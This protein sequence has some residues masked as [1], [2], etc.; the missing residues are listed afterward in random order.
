MEQFGIK[1][2]R[3]WFKRVIKKI[4][5]KAGVTRAAIGI[6]TGARAEIYF[7]GA[8]ESVSFDAIEELAAKGTDLIFIEK[9]GIIDE[10]KEHADRYGVTM[11]NSRGYLTEYAH[12]LIK[13]ANRSGANITVITDYDLSGINLASK[14][15]KNVYFITMDDSTLEYFGLVKDERLVVEATNKGLTNRVEKVIHTDSRFAHIDIEFL[16][17]SRIE[18]N[19][20]IA[21]V[22]DERFWNFIMDK[23]NARFPTR[24]YNRAIQTPSKDEN[25]D[26]IDL[27]PKGMKSLITHFR[28]KVSDV[29]ED[30]EAQ[31]KEE[32]EKVERFLEVSKQREKNKNRVMKVIAENQDIC[33]IESEVLKLCKSLNIDLIDTSSEQ[34]NGIRNRRKR[35]ASFKTE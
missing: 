20:V 14:C 13:T 17:H 8:W 24:N 32:Q 6:V 28:N 23:V 22:G 26:E 5:D 34:D 21:R 30:V 12:D 31:I 16:K 4:C 9:E 25:A 33:E 1:V 19:G 29:V 10:L 7:D 18:I 27:Y 11:V 35:G 3:D 15:D 2:S